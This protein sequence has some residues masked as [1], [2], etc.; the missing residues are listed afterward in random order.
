[1]LVLNSQSDMGGRHMGTI[2]GPGSLIA[3]ITAFANHL[4]EKGETTIGSNVKF[5][6]GG[7]GNNQMTAANRAGAKA[8]IISRIADDF[9]GQII[10]AHYDSEKMC[11]DYIKTENSA[12]TG[13]ALIEVSQTTAENRIIVIK[14][15]CGNVSA[16]DVLSAE[17][18]FAKCDVVLTQLE[19][20][21]ESVSEAK[22]LAQ[23]YNKVFILNPA[24]FQKVPN[25]FFDGA[26]YITPNETE[27]EFFTG[28]PITDIESVKKC[29]KVFRD[30]GVKNVIITLGVKGVFYSGCED[31]FLVPGIKVDAVDTS[32][33]GDAFNG[34]FA[35]A[36]SEKTDIK[37][38][39]QF[40]NCTGALSVTKSGTA[41]SMPKR[42]EILDLMT[43]IYNTT[44]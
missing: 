8:V 10:K 27:A 36:I 43:E 42:K 13:T 18:E 28:I 2:V 38:A 14:G 41:Q 37:R 12:A 3:D 19:T 22:K 6:P 20:N 16:E 7:K 1:M 17:K 31:E 39:L 26:D 11:Q 44:I 4:P 25:G 34:G 24:P 21:I 33:A 29:A 5:G 40:A 15:V 9:L 35:T 23:K 30:M 32:G